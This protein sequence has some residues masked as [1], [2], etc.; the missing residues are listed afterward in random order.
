M[1]QKTK[2]IGRLLLHGFIFMKSI[3]MKK[4]SVARTVYA[5][6]AGH[7]ERLVE[8]GL[9]TPVLTEKYSKEDLTYSWKSHRT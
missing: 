9:Y 1:L 2:H 4:S 3:L 5:D 6:F 8:K 7:V